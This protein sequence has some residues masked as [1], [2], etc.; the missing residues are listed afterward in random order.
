MA[1]QVKVWRC[2]CGDVEPTPG[3]IHSPTQWVKDLVLL[4]LQCRSEL[5]LRFDPCP[6]NFHVP[7]VWPKKKPT[8]DMDV[9]VAL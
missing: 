3:L 2:L 9:Q 8:V 1:Q 5:R 6:G 7:Q 4:Q